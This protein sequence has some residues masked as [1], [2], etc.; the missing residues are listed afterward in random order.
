MY[1]CIYIHN[2]L[3]DLRKTGQDTLTAILSEHTSMVQVFQK[4]KWQFYKPRVVC[5]L[6]MS[7]RLAVPR[8]VGAQWLHVP[9]SRLRNAE[10]H[11]DLMFAV[12]R[13][14]N[15]VGWELLKDEANVTEANIESKIVW[16]LDMA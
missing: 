4:E 12:G 2:T 13:P 8:N 1:V 7:C 6:K 3:S 11:D 9:S 10:R 14:V 15:N 5:K 16:N